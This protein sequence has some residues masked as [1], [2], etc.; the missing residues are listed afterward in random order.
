MRQI[1]EVLRLHHEAGLSY[2][3]CARALKIGRS[4]V[5]KIVLLARAA[6]I[7]CVSAQQMSDGAL[8]QGVWVRA[9]SIPRRII[10][11]SP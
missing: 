1:R 9:P 10:R 7:D 2:G 6:G 5:G 11:P 8:E 4:T 3:E